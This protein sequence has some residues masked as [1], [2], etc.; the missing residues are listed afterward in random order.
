MQQE[1]A[2]ESGDTGDEHAPQFLQ[3]RTCPRDL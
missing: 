1:G 2:Q 3:G